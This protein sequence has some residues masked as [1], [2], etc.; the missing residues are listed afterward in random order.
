MN[1]QKKKKEVVSI[2]RL[3]NIY[4]T[5]DDARENILK[6]FPYIIFYSTACLGLFFYESYKT[7]LVVKGQIKVIL[8]EFE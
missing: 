7:L 1:K 3:R 5:T 2:E 8:F 4:K 6:C